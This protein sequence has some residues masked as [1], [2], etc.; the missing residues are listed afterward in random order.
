VGFHLGFEGFQVE[1]C[2][3]P[4]LAKNERDVGHPLLS[5]LVLAASRVLVAEQH[6]EARGCPSLYHVCLRALATK[7]KE[8]A[9]QGPHR[10]CAIFLRRRIV[11]MRFQFEQLE[12]SLAKVEQLFRTSWI[13]ALRGQ[14]VGAPHQAALV[15]RGS[16]DVKFLVQAHSC[17][18]SCRCIAGSWGSAG[19]C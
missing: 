19:V 14:I 9:G 3:I 6:D 11:S 18:I 10:E 2:G 17:S 8:L 12:L 5:F 16:A 1:G 13:C 4:H 7:P 15:R